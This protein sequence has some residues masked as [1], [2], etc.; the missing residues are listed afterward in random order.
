MRLCVGMRKMRSPTG[1]THEAVA[2]DARVN[3]SAVHHQDRSGSP[4]LRDSSLKIV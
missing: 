1:V 4:S 3:V 2:D